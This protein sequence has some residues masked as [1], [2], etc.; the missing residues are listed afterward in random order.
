MEIICPCCENSIK[1][2]KHLF[3]YSKTKYLI[4]YECGSYFQ[5]KMKSPSY[6][7][8]NWTSIIDPDGKIRDMTKER[9]FKLKNWYGEAINFVNNLK[10]GKILDIGA[11]LGFFLSDISDKWEKSAIEP[12]SFAQN[13]I[14][15]NYSDVNIIN[16]IYL[17][18]K[19]KNYYDVIMFYHVIEHLENPIEYLEKIYGSLK[20][21]GILIIGTPNCNS[22]ASKFFKGNYRLLG[23]THLSLFN[24]LS[25]ENILKRKGFKLIKKEYPFFKTKYFNFINLLK[26]L[27]FWKLSP[28]FYGNLMT[29][30]V[31]KI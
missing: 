31:Q 7:E 23:E 10:P 8:S 19:N 29:F 5:E 6:E 4:C 14:T 13:Y 24:P 17:N 1:N 11:G 18:S 25:L 30:Y 26:M 2:P 3:D 21:N 9:E 27:L 22:L 28:P 20:K 12:S 16:E 15:K